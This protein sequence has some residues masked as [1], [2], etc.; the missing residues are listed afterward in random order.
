MER[1][2][3]RTSKERGI[4][5]IALIVT[6]IVMVIL[7]GTGISMLFGE[8]G[9]IKKAIEAK[10]KEEIA[11]EQE[12]LDTE[13]FESMV[14][15]KGT[16]PTV[17]SVVDHFIEQG[18]ASRDDVTTNEDGSKD[19][20]TDND[21]SAHIEEDENGDVKVTVDGKNGET[22]PRIIKITYTITTNSIEIQVNA[23]G[24]DTYIYEYLQVYLICLFF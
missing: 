4:T 7:A 1:E 23:V 6:I 13:V 2:I 21:F 11:E 20:V 9:L 24:A 16:Q 8:N 15:M 18:I 22:P 3:K 5:L 19:I 17:D 14:D 10:E 12:R